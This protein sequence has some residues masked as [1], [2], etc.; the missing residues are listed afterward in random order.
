[1][2][3]GGRKKKE[4]EEEKASQRERERSIVYGRVGIVV[5]AEFF[6]ATTRN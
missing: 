1:M 4:R 6:Y 3:K 2:T 5:A